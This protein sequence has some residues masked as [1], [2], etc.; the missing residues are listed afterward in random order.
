MC[1]RDRGAKLAKPDLPMIG[2]GGDGSLLMRLGELEVFARTGIAVPLVIVNDQS[3]GTMKWRQ[4]NRDM[5]DYGLDF[6]P[7][8]LAMLAKSC[9]LNGVTVN[10]PEEFRRELR[11]AMNSDKSTLIDARVDPVEYQKGFGKASGV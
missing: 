8:D 1:I 2:L 7:V 9:G 10:T 11:L 4:K 5:T 3:L 6:Y